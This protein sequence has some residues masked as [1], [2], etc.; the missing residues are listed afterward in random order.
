MTQHKS[1]ITS[2]W[3]KRLALLCMVIDHTAVALI[4]L[5]I[6]QT[7]G[8][9]SYESLM[10]AFNIY[11]WMRSIGRLA[12][13]IYLFLLVEGFHKTHDFKKYLLRMGGMAVLSE[14]PFDLALYGSW[15]YWGHQNVLFEFFLLLI[16]FHFLQKF[17]NSLWYQA[18]IISLILII[19]AFVM[20]DY[21]LFGIVA[22]VLFY[23]AYGN[24]TSQALIVIPAMSFEWFYPTVFLSAIPIFAYK[25]DKGKLWSS[26]HY[27][28]YPLH[29]IILY[30]VRLYFFGH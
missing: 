8:Q 29:L 2:A 15:F 26:L 5:G 24:R 19:T 17:K 25:G 6:L 7:E 30:F 14:V 27:W 23:Y 1:L 4:E 12:F 21:D 13:P 10:T 9:Y 20:P 18:L 16:L 3:L 11:T 22:G 28:A